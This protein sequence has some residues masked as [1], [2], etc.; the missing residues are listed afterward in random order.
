MAQSL[1]ELKEALLLQKKLRTMHVDGSVV[2]KGT[3]SANITRALC[4]IYVNDKSYTYAQNT[5]QTGSVSASA[6][7]DLKE[8][9]VVTLSKQ[10]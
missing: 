1:L 3:E 4:N 6:L 5:E 8:G 9:D 7:L 2:Y 10:I